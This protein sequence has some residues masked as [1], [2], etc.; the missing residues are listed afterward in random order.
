M[1]MG[2]VSGQVGIFMDLMASI[3]AATTTS[4]PADTKLEGIN[5][6]PIPGGRLPR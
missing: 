5:L 2:Q 4:V 6:L 3:L 1:W